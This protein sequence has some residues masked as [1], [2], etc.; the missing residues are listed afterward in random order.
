MP[1]FLF[2]FSIRLSAMLQVKSSLWVI[3]VTTDD[4]ILIEIWGL[5]LYLRL[6]LVLNLQLKLVVL[7]LQLL[8][9]GYLRLDSNS[10]RSEYLFIIIDF[11]IDFIAWFIFLSCE[12]LSL[13]LEGWASSLWM[14]I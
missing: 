5:L 13:V 6:L 10:M 9:I 14:E 2:L 8:K 4:S 7:P 3:G 1:I 11:I 12:G